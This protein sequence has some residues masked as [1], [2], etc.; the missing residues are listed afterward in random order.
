VIGA[1]AAV[2]TSASAADDAKMDKC[3]GI[4]KAGENSCA[5]AKGGH[6]CAGQSKAAYSGQDFKAVPAGSCEKMN[7][8]LTPFEGA[9]PKIKS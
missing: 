6:S 3:Y 8:S 1:A 7:G 2:T 9:N 5:A 4:S